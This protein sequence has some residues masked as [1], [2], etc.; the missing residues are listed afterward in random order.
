VRITGSYSGIGDG[1]AI[2]F[3][4]AATDYARIH[5]IVEAGGEVGLV[6]K[7][8]GTQDRLHITHGGNVGI[9]TSMTSAAGR[10]VVMGGAVGLG[11]TRTA[12]STGLAV[13]NGNVG[14]GTWSANSGL[15]VKGKNASFIST[16]GTN[17]N[18]TGSGELY[19]QGD[20]EVDGTIYG[21]GSGI[22]GVIPSAAGWTDGGANVYTTTT[23]DNVGIGTTTPTSTLEVVK[24][25]A[26]TAPL[27]VS[28]TATS[29]GNLLIVSSAGNVSIGTTTTNAA[30]TIM[31]GNVGIGTTGPAQSLVTAGNL[32]VVGRNIYG[33]SVN[34]FIFLGD[35]GG[36]SI[37]Y[38]SNANA[39]FN[40]T[41]T[42][43]NWSTASLLMSTIPA[44]AITY[45]SFNQNVGIGTTIPLGALTVMSG[46]V[47]VGTWKPIYALDV[48][49]DGRLSGGTLHGANFDRIEVGVTNNAFKFW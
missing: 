4:D 15:E 44:T 45:A 5:D 40:S 2:V 19:V 42:S 35:A 28:S 30:L 38:G 41:A 13:M 33:D 34:P 47:G 21:D 24:T 29:D 12:A 25:A 32:Q 3:G 16:G 48:V 27:M 18:A 11:T 26:G 6:F 49:G 36:T 23:T 9:G 8:Q 1:R 22:T 14:I 31:N 10:L 39:T 20:L 7:T 46:N 17:T 37:G 43:L